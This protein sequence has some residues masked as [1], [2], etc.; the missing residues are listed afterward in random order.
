MHSIGSDASGASLRCS[1]GDAEDRSVGQKR[2]GTCRCKWD[3]AT[4]CRTERSVDDCIDESW[5]W[6]PAFIVGECH[7]RDERSDE[8]NRQAGAFDVWICEVQIG[9]IPYQIE[10]ERICAQ[11]ANGV[12]AGQADDAVIL[13]E[14]GLQYWV[15]SVDEIIDEP[16]VILRCDLEDLVDH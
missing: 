16:R 10:A 11:V 12:F 5:V 2:H 3:W 15:Q 6:C 4:G 13:W 8:I 14:D 7:A 9:A 1:W